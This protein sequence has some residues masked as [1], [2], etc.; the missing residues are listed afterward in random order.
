M[1]GGEE[2]NLGA[3]V[4]GDAITQLFRYYRVK[5]S[6]TSNTDRDESPILQGITASFS[7]FKK[8]TNSKGFEYHATISGVASLTTKIDLFKKST[9]GQMTVDVAF[10]QDMSTYF[11]TPRKNRLAKIFQGFKGLV[12]DDFIN[13]YYGVIGNIS[14]GSGETLSVDIDDYTATWSKPV[15]ATWETVADDITWTN[16]HPIDVLLDIFQN[17][18]DVRDSFILY[19]TFN[20]VKA[21]I[22]TW[23]VSRTITGKSEDSAKLIDELRQLMS[24]FFIPQPD[25][26]ISIKR[27][28]PTASAVAKITDDDYIKAPSLSYDGNYKELINH[29]LTYYGWDGTG[30]NLDDYT[31]LDDFPNTTSISD[32]KEEKYKTVKDKWTLAT[33]S[34]QIEDRRDIIDGVFSDSPSILSGNLSRKLLWL[35]VGDMVNITIRRYPK[36]GGFGITDKKFL[37][38]SRNYHY[39]DSQVG[40]S[41]L[42]V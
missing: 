8:L 38:V 26:K 11:S 15:P 9:I 29:L 34:S 27:F 7:T 40:V 2:T 17:H 39:K 18:L 16:M 21:A 20:T 4:D 3:I 19:S 25:G 41:F 36:S 1:F 24:C 10:N 32:W 6:F 30:D 42:E 23:V 31:A 28:D 35:E 12:E 33:Q 5:A 14:I 22:P 13:Y 37:L